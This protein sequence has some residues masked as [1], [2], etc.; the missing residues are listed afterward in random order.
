M[1]IYRTLLRAKIH[2]AVVTAAELHY[3]GSLTVDRALMEA[4]CL[5]EFELVQVVDVENGARF[6]TYLIAGQ[7]GSG[8]IQVNGAAARLAAVG[9]HVI[10]MAYAQVAEPLPED[11]QPAIVLVDEYNHRIIDPVHG[12]EPCC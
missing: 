1:A 11:W 8:V 6:E 7:A 9:D 5:R 10:I 12:G 2:R 4:A 3:Q